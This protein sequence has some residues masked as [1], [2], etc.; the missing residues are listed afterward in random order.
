M[1]LSRGQTMKHKLT[2]HNLPQAT[3]PPPSDKK[4]ADKGEA[5]TPPAAS[6]YLVMKMAEWKDI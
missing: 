4:G 1:N 6:L 2:K 5:V 3:I